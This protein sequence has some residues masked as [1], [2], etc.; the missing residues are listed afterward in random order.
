MFTDYLLATLQPLINVM[1]QSLKNYLWPLEIIQLTT[2]CLQDVFD[3][4]V[5]SYMIVYER[6]F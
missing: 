5:L 4:A 3:V 1:L 6:A 2:H